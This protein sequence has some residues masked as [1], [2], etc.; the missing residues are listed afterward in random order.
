MLTQGVTRDSREARGAGQA[1]RHALARALLLEAADG[2]SQAGGLIGDDAASA[3]L[4][5][6]ADELAGLAYRLPA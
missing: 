3:M 4:R 5:T 1:P 6:V 2:I